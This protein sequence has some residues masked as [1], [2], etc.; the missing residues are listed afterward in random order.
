MF[1]KKD[2]WLGVSWSNSV[3][4]Y[5]FAKLANV[6]LWLFVLYNVTNELNKIMN[7]T[8]TWQHT[9]ACTTMYANKINVVGSTSG[10][11]WQRNMYL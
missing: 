4:F 9:P 11:F 1:L 8:T 6:V 2:L 10:F 3:L 5:H 7:K